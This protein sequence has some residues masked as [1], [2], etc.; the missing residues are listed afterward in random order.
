MLRMSDI[1]NNQIWLKIDGEI[2]RKSA[3]E[4][5]PRRSFFPRENFNKIVKRIR[6]SLGTRAINRERSYF[7]GRIYV[8]KKALFYWEKCSNDV[9][10][11]N[12]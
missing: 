9:A 12:T 6:Q 8:K 5:P 7:Q 4:H 11:K 1:L 2:R 3:G 10:N